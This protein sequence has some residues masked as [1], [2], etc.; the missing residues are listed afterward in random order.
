MK[1]EKKPEWVE[2]LANEELINRGIEALKKPDEGEDPLKN[3][4]LLIEVL[5][6]FKGKTNEEV[7]EVFSMMYTILPKEAQEAIGYALMPLEAKAAM[8]VA[9]L[10]KN[11]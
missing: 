5:E 9:H 6:K 3:P 1:E 2:Q 8:L 10:A 7:V 4:Q 11:N